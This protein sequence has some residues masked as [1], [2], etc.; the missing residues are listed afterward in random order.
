M[1]QC[2][3]EK[4]ANSMDKQLQ[5]IMDVLNQM[6]SN[7]DTKFSA[8]EERLNKLEKMDSIE[9]RVIVNQIDITDMKDILLRLEGQPAEKITE[10]M[11]DVINRL[12]KTF[13]LHLQE[14]NKRLD[15]QLLKIA[16]AEEEI[17]MLKVHES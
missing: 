3:Y 4:G 16:K 5:G 9:H 8:I 1:L 13:Q 10:V 17:L 12:E 7:I 11:S 6:N 14:V 2:P 15:S